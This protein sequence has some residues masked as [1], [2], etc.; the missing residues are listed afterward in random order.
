MASCSG[1]VE[2]VGSKDVEIKRGPKAGSTS[3]VYSFKIDGE[4]YKTGFK[5]MVNKGDNVSFNYTDGAYGKDV[6]VASLSKLDG[7]AEP[8]SAGERMATV[9][10]GYGF[11]MGLRDK[12]RAINRQNALTN[13]VAY[14]GVV[15]TEGVKI[16]PDLVIEIARTFEAYTTGDI[17]REAAAKLAEVGEE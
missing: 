8:V 4:W 10:S 1:V 12:G 11:P 15:D 16:T 2:A 3:K 17:E 9:A 6:Q 5:S 13:A 14:L 7:G